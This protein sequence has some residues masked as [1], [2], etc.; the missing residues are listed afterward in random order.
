MSDKIPKRLV[1]SLSA[2]FSLSLAIFFKKKV[3]L[4]DIPPFELLLQLMVISA[5]VLT[6][7]LFLIQ[8][9]DIIK[10]KK[11]TNSQRQF[12]ILAGTFLLAAYLFTTFGLE[13]TTSINYSFLSRSTLIFTTILAFFFAFF[14]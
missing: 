10:I 1:Y 4:V 11:I 6:L 9:I 14:P 5:I 12:I 13:F 2:V 7:N 3:L 8:K